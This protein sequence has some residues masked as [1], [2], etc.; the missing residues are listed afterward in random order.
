MNP[1]F[2]IVIIYGSQTGTARCLAE[3]LA[4][5][6]CKLLRLRNYPA[7]NPASLIHLCSANDYTPLQQ[8]AHEPG[9]VIFVCSTTGF[10]D[11]PDNMASFWRKIMNVR[12]PEGRTFPTTLR[13]AVLGVGDSSY[14]HY[15]YVAKKL[16]RRMVHL[17]GSPLP[18]SMA[19]ADAE[20]DIGLGLADESAPEGMCACLR[21]FMPSLW[22]TVLS[23]YGDSVQQIGS[24]VFPLT[25]EA[26]E[27]PIFIASFQSRFMV[28]R[29]RKRE[30]GELNLMNG[31]TFRNDDVLAGVIETTVARDEAMFKAPAIP[32]NASWF[33]VCS[34]ERLTPEKYFQDTRLIRLEPEVINKPFVK[35]ERISSQHFQ[36]IGSVKEGSPAMRLS[37]VRFL[38][39]AP[40]HHPQGAN[41]LRVVIHHGPFVKLS[42]RNSSFFSLTT[43]PWIFSRVKF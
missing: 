3:R 41:Y 5:Q 20:Q 31:I 24:P 27:S 19:L 26:L 18:V 17:G 15:N 12:L 34:N 9:P 4:L 6:C 30:G 36:E 22:N 43:F 35:C 33:V 16:Y 7:D 2:R 42:L 28:K 21:R 37:Q 39:S 23:H 25:W 14:K 8:L 40:S 10:G 1:T 11:P 38:V 29:V 32:N 13:F